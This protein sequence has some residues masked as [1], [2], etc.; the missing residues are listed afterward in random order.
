M[1][2]HRQI[3]LRMI[4]VS[5]NIF[6][7]NQNTCF[8]SQFFFFRKLW[9]VRDNVEKYDGA[10][11]T[12]DDNIIRRMRFTCWINKATHTTHSERVILC[13]T[14]RISTS[15]VVTQASH[16][17]YIV[18]LVLHVLILSLALSESVQWKDEKC[19]AGNFHS[20]AAQYSSRLEFDAMFWG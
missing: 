9:H 6:R 3:L 15:T 13:C 16:Y 11:Q 17:T 14:Y 5:H 7:E 18:C 20:G 12:T 2:K 19:D 4:N 8:I 10:G 1:I